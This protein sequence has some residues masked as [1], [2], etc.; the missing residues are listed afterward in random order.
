MRR[1]PHVEQP[2]REQMATLLR[3]C[4]C[5]S[6]ADLL[7]MTQLSMSTCWRWPRHA[8]SARCTAD[9]RRRIVRPFVETA[10]APW[11]PPRARAAAMSLSGD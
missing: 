6:D 2:T 1:R 4:G 5:H 3:I 10:G 7:E 8:H 11:R 9:H